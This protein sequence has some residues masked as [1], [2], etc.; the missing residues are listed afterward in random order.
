MEENGIEVREYGAVISDVA[1]LASNQLNA[2]SAVKGTQAEVTGNY[3]K[4]MKDEFELIWA[5]PTS[6]CYALYSKLDADKN[7][8]ELEGL[9]RAHVHDGVVVVQYLVWLDHQMQEI[10]G[11]SGYFLAD[12]GANKKKHFSKPMR[13]PRDLPIQASAS[14][15]CKDTLVLDKSSPSSETIE[16][17]PK[18]IQ[19]IQTEQKNSSIVSSKARAHLLVGIVKM[20]QQTL[21]LIM[22]VQV[23]VA[24]SKN[25]VQANMEHEFRRNKERFAFLKW[26]SSAFRNFQGRVHALTRANYLASSSTSAA[27]RFSF[28]TMNLCDEILLASSGKQKGSSIA[29]DCYCKSWIYGKEFYDSKDKTYDLNFKEAGIVALTI[30]DQAVSSMEKQQ[31]SAVSQTIT[32]PNGIAAL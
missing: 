6:C 24:R 3:T 11:A 29:E 19:E 20:F 23:D 27:A 22:N 2:L 13:Q 30:D 31:M 7:P 16:A 15:R 9:K 25:A 4:E 28:L 8:V 32:I 17:N 18:A 21:L 12:V 1:L 10:Y 14:N 5:D 26:G